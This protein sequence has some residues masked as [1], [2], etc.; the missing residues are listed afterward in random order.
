[1]ADSKATN[2]SYFIEIQDGDDIYTGENITAQN[3]EEAEL[4]AMILFGFLLSDD[5]E[6]ITFEENKIH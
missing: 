2:K 4:K 3:K 6:I 5:A 1:M